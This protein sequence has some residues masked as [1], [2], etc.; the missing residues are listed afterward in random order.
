MP[1]QAETLI[2]QLLLGNTGPSQPEGTEVLVLTIAEKPH[3]GMYR[4]S[5]PNPLP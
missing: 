2:D 4:L 1:T 5:G 3:Y